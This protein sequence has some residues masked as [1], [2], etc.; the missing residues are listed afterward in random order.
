MV[1]VHAQD[2]FFINLKKKKKEILPD[3][4][5]AKCLQCAVHSFIVQLFLCPYGH[6]P[7]SDFFKQEHKHLKWEETNFYPLVILNVYYFIHTDS[8]AMW[9]FSFNR[10]VSFSFLTH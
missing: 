9:L 3:Y 10:L 6:L 2:F 8:G 1:Y 4:F 7:W 5:D